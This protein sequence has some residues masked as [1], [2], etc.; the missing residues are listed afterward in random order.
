[1]FQFFRNFFKTKVGLAI[2]LAFLGLIALAFAS[3]DV[4]STG[5]FGGIAGGNR[6]AV[7]GDEKISTAD[8]VQSTNN[9]LDRA[10]QE[11][12]TIT[13]P[14]LLRE[15]GLEAALD[16][17]I[18]R[19]ALRGFAHDNG[20]RAG[21]NLI[22]SEIRMI[23]AF[24]GPD[25][26]FSEDTYRQ[27]LAQQRISEK[28]VRDDLGLGLLSQQIIL[29]AG[30]G[31][32]VPDKIA[33]RYAQLFKERRQGAIALVP[34]A[35]FAPTGKADP[36][37]LQA[38]YE[39]N[40]DLFIRPEERVIRYA[41]FDATALG[42]RAQPTE[43]EI[44]AR[45]KRDAASYAAAE[46]RNVTQI[47]VPTEAA[48]K[49]LR[50]R[51][52][53]GESFDT[54]AR[55]AGLR[56]TPLTGVARQALAAQTSPAVANAYFTAA[57]GNVSEPARSPLGWHIARIDAIETKPAQTLEQVRGDIAQTLGEEKRVRGLADLASEI[58]DQ[59]ST[60]ATLSEVAEDLG[61]ALETTGPTLADGRV[62]AS[63]GKPLPD[64]LRPAL[65]T[66]F[67]MDEEEPE[68][69]PVA[70][71]QTYLVFEVSDIKPA[72]AAPFDQIEEL[73]A[74]RWRA[75]EG[76]KAAQVAADRIMKRLREGQ[77][78]AKALAAEKVKL[79]PSQTIRMT[80]EDLARQRERRIPPPI[81][82]LF[83]M[84]EGT[85]K[86]LNA[87]GSAGFFVVQL[88][89]ITMDDMAKDDPLIAQAQRQMGPLMGAEFSEQLGLAMRKEQGVSRNQTAIDA[90][91][92]QL[93]GN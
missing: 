70:N 58:D 46:T 67:Q 21:D 18:N 68:I 91:R 85:A 74:A 22:N 84:A 23:P 64:V 75:A 92:K 57:R 86:K 55:E 34:S 79:P 53:A 17:L 6:V 14:A 87:G 41:T 89:D 24:R 83:S 40:R 5:T 15:G 8:L 69:A 19:A 78:M 11:Q 26:N 36:K 7:V 9:E 43:A 63:S 13:M 54:V 88:D 33:Y 31:T 71:G 76:E 93:A 65:A 72:A 35:A 47:I 30:F 12:P 52:Q 59:L 3:A 77:T 42:E 73:V 29:P 39:K 16:A 27:A 49:S 38:Y 51:V 28:Q 90:V 44:A 4:S 82:L 37:V 45:F 56:A 25:G 2:S 50:Q 60:G 48:A 80:R 66:A 62:A 81:A 32:T 20:Y 10:R 1:M 61:L